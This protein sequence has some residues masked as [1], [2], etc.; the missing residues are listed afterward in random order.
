MHKHR[1]HPP[2]PQQF[3]LTASLKIFLRN[4]HRNLRGKLIKN[5]AELQQKNGYFF[6]YIVHC[7]FNISAVS[8][9]YSFQ[10]RNTYYCYVIVKF[11]DFL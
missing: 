7:H 2:F 9:F 5:N 10:K 3:L 11:I 1:T 6:N 4:N 8:K